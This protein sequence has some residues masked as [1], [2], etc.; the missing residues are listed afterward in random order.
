MCTGVENENEWSCDHIYCQDMVEISK[1]STLFEIA[2][3]EFSE[4]FPVRGIALGYQGNWNF[5][6]ASMIAEF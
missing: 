4:K 1:Y 2:M 5:R 6:S 3:E